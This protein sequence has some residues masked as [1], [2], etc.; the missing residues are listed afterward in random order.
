MTDSRS[1]V[2]II[3]GGAAGLM[4]AL[5]A[6]ESGAKV[7]IYEKMHLPGLKLGITGKGRCNVTTA[8]DVETAIREFGA[9]GLFLRSAFSRFYNTELLE[10]LETFG[11]P[12]VLERGNRYFLKSGRATDLVKSFRRELHQRGVR[13]CTNTPAISIE[14][15]GG[16][17]AGVMIPGDAGKVVTA[18]AVILATGGKSYPATGATGDGYSLA[19]RLGHTIVPPCAA[20][21]PIVFKGRVLNSIIGLHLKNVELTLTQSGKQV[22]VEFGE[23]EFTEYGITGPAVLPLGTHV[24][25]GNAGAMSLFVNFKPALDIQQLQ[26][27]I[28]RELASGGAKPA[29]AILKTL[30]PE[31]A[32]ETFYAKWG[33]PYD[34]LCSEVRAEE[35]KRLAALLRGLEFEVGGTRPIS[36]AV[37]TAGGVSLKD[38]S[39]R[40]MESKITRGLYICGELLDVNGNTGGYNLQA[41]FSTGWIAG[42]SAAGDAAS[43]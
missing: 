34:R 16:R 36:D 43:Q 2:I 3:G 41:A 11:V 33:I 18:C 38:V 32:I 7:T 28:Q 17:I 20:L 21:I 4:A 23:A 14:A 35:R 5:A 8:N 10:L 26:S 22:A 24:S 12:V 31:Q 27:R 9:N 19:A 13:M 1:P 30:L 39:P 40:T 6:A 42:K 37:V 25:L 15:E 29:R